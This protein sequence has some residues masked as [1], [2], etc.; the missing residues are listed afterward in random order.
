MKRPKISKV[1]HTIELTPTAPFNFDATLH[2]PDHFPAADTQWE[3]GTRWQTMLWQGQPLGLKFENRGTVARPRIA[4]SIWSARQ[5]DSDFLG[6]LTD[7]IVYRYNLQLGLTEFYQRFKTH[8]TLGPILRRWRGMRPMNYSSLYEYLI[9]AIVLQNATV[10]RSVSMM[11]ALL[12]QYGTLLSFD[13]QKL[14]CFWE[15]Q[16]MDVATE[17]ELRALKIGY[18]AKSI[19]RVTEAFVGGGIDEFELRGRSREE[20]RQALLDLYGIGPASVGYILLDVFHHMNELEYISPWEQKIYSKLFFDTDPDEPVPVDQ[21]LAYFDEQFGEYRMLAVH[22]FWE[23][24][25]WKRKNRHVKWLER[26]IRL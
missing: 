26:L 7:E 2:K 17:Q 25:F 20:Q 18:R 10:R 12:E 13:G 22:Y 9:I 1:K 14:Y 21:L 24:L 11:Q 4:L 16:D 19:K 5:L 8:L 6:Q 23:D 3:P 15:P